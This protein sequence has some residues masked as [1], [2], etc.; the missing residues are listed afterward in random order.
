MKIL[1]V[2]HYF[3]PE[4]NAPA[5]RTHEHARRWVAG[6]PRRH[7]HHGRSEPSA[8]PDLPGLPEP[9][10][11]GGDGRRHPRDPDLDVPD[12]R[13]TAS[14]AASLNY[15]LFAVTAILASF[16]AER[17]DVVVATS[18][19]FFVGVAGAVIAR[20]KRRPFVLEVRDLWPKSIVAARPAAQP[21]P[22]P[23]SKRSR[24]WLYRSA[25]GI[26]VNT[27]TFIDHIAARGVAERARSSSSTTASTRRCSSRGRRIASCSR[28]HG[29]EDR[30]T[31]A[32]V[33]TLGLAHGLVTRRRRRRAAARRA[34][35]PVRPD[36]RRR[37]PRA[38]R[39]RDARARP[40]ERPLLG[41]QPARRD[42]GLDRVDRPAARDAAR[43]ARA[44]RP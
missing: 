36:R 2:S 34:G 19:Q 8:R 40:R 38:A 27:R 9:L 25:A 17:P 44:S 35:R 13:T 42:A 20:L 12:A 4:V 21:D 22:G 43:P 3:P 5:N 18:P 11:P 15:L 30:F 26:V 37:R 7:R 33:G 39:G 6:R 29:L 23:L 41:L 28:A 14:C 31:V 10:D 32:Y 16:R 1:F 24:R